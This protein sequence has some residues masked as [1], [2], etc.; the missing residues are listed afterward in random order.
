MIGS[1]G[2]GGRAY[3]SYPLIA[4]SSMGS[5]QPGTMTGT[6]T[7]DEDFYGTRTITGTCDETYTVSGTF[8]SEDSF[9]GVFMAD[10]SGG[11]C[12]NCTQQTWNIEGVRQE[13]GE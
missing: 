10:F 2:E 3:S 13:S 5:S 6:I 1:W 8:T 9:E 4:V 11:M 12:L 7:G